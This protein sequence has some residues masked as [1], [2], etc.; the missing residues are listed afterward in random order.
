VLGPRERRIGGHHA[1][2]L[3]ARELDERERL[4]YRRGPERGRAR[5]TRAEEIARAARRE[6]GLG[7]A[8]A[9]GRRR[10]LGEAARALARPVVVRGAK[11][12][13]PRRRAAAEVGDHAILRDDPAGLDHLV[14]EHEA[15][16]REMVTKAVRASALPAAYKA[17]GLNAQKLADTLHAAARGLKQQCTS[18]AEFGER[19]GFTLRALCMP[20]VLAI[21]RANE[22]F[23]LRVQGGK[24]AIRRGRIP[25][26]LLDDIGE[27]VAGVEHATLRGVVEGGRPR[28]YAEGNL[29]PDL[30]QRLRNVMGTW[31]TAQIRQARRP[32]IK[33]WF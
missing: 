29:G 4:P 5:L 1:F 30:K 9:V 16:F 31:S 24:V 18:R 13:Q 12:A 15:R 14:A 26:R 11:E 17:V 10:E 2:G 7:E 28:L 25:Q 6:I 19:F 27:I 23:F 3:G 32:R 33:S 20:L 21:L 8:E 22:L